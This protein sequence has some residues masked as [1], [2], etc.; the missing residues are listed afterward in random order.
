[1]T[2]G[3]AAL[4]Q[5]AGRCGIPAD[6]KAVSANLTIVVPRGYGVLTIYPGDAPLPLASTLNF[7]PGQVRANNAMVLLAGDGSGRIT[8]FASIGG[9]GTTDLIL[10][11]NGYFK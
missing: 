9:D 4:F 2:T 7:S 8:A 11:V 1:M 5:V 6:A 3:K 10:D